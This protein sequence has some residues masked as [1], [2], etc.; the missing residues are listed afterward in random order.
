MALAHDIVRAPDGT[1]T[2]SLLLLHGILGSGANLRTIARR[3]VQA[4]PD[5]AAVLV[6]LRRHGASLEASGPDT[7]AQAAEDVA[8]LA[9]SLEAPARA[10]LAHSFGGKVALQWLATE[11]AGLEHA[12][13]VDSTPGARVDAR[14]S[15]STVRVVEMLDALPYPFASREAF[16]KAVQ[17]Q[18]PR[19]AIAPWLAM[20][21]RR[22][23]DGFRF[24]PPIP[25]IRALLASY[26]ASDLWGVVEAPPEG[27]SLHF[28]IGER[29]GVLDEADRARL[30]ALAS[31]QPG[32]VTVDRLPTDH[33]VHAEDPE[34]L[35]RVMLARMG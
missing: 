34:G 12:F 30:D 10:V 8:S 4:R 25:S 17:E 24:G 14:G 19:P 1:P 11:R 9:R 3:F 26:F 28:V 23:D 13:V 2:R 21:L 31:R 33:W 32:R 7:L 35:V 18:D 6:D 22:G 5:W 27:T 29:S 20:S 16:V 15:E